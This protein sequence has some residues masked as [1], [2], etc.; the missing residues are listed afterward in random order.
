MISYKPLWKTLEKK[1]I[2]Q[3]RLI[4]EYGISAGQL[5]RIRT[6]NHISTKTI[7]NLCKVLDC[8]VKDIIEYNK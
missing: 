2:S 8:D 1:G 7:E 5:S 4:K 6:N 3:Y